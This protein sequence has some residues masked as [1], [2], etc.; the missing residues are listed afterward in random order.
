VIADDVDLPVDL[1][2]GDLVALAATGAYTYAM[3]SNVNRVGRPAVV[4]VRDGTATTW[5]RREDAADLDRLETG[6]GRIA[7]VVRAPEGVDIRA[8]TPRDA[9]PFLEFWAAIV[10]EGRYVRSET[11]RHPARVYR[12][13]FRR[14]WTDREAQVVAM[15]GE[16]VVG[17]LY[18]QRDEHPVTHHVATIGIAVA[19]SHRGRGI[20]SALMS[21]CLRWARGVGVEKVI[22]SVYPHNA[23]AIA[24]YRKFGFVE[25][26]RLARQSRKSYGDA[27]EILMA[28]WL[29]RG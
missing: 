9:R 2:P 26:G 11:V 28:T 18:V 8:A 20:G 25:E 15:D 16:R 3:A 14:A 22:L 27:D 19:A 17:H 24:L 4:G 13:R 21:E 29:G 12:A 7:P 5:L 6:A 10:A 1:R 23:A